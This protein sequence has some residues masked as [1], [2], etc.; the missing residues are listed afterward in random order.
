M[1]TVRELLNE[2]KKNNINIHKTQVIMD[3]RLQR[4]GLR[5]RKIGNLYAIDDNIAR[6]YIRRRKEQ[7]KN[8]KKGNNNELQ[9][10]RNRR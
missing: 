6:E 10:Y 3:I 1:I 4:H 7:H 9:N 2:L 5:A 8:K